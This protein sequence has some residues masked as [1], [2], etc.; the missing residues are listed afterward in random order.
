MIGIGNLD[1]NLSYGH[2]NSEPH[3][4]CKKIQDYIYRFSDHIGVG[5]FSKVYKG[6]HQITSISSII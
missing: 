3:P 6:T 4:D 1:K 2:D 5:N